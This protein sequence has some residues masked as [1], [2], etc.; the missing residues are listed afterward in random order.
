MGSQNSTVRIPITY[1]IM[2][3]CLLMICYQFSCLN[4]FTEVNKGTSF[5]RHKLLPKKGFKEN[6]KQPGRPD[7]TGANS[8]DKQSTFIVYL[9]LKSLA[10]LEKN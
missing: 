5:Q 2:I 6:F 3:R 1:V 4:L 8:R 7:W 9:F 10:H